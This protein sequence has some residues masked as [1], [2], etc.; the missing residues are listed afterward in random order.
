MTAQAHEGVEAIGALADG[1][2]RSAYE[3][4]VQRGGGVSR[5][6]VADALGVPVHT[7]RLHLE[8]LVDEGLLQ[9]EERRLS[10]RSG[11]GA[12]RPAR[13]YSRSPQ[14]V[15]ISLPPRAYDLA[16]QIFAAATQRSLL[17]E[18]LAVTLSEEARSVGRAMAA[19]CADD[20]EPSP[21]VGSTPVVGDRRESS[22]EAERVAGTL[23]GH[24]YEP[25]LREGVVWLRNCPFDRLAKEH[26][27]LVC[28]LNLDVVGGVIDGLGCQRVEAALDPQ[29]GQC[30]VRI[31]PTSPSPT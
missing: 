28:G 15:S 29:P 1:L 9:V 3:L 11:P 27:E 30:C 22:G 21:A 14:E 20:H 10:G 25:D 12:G 18:D 24:G 31:S 13:L 8:R 23:A 6:E 16:A 5:Q 4:V 17:G 2:R 26:T 19:A 7:A